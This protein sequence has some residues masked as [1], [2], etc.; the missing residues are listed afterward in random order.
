MGENDFSDIEEQIKNSVQNALNYIDFAGIKNTINTS[1]EKTMNEVKSQ[2]KEK[3]GYF[4]KKMY[5][6]SN[7]I[8]RK[9]EEFTQEKEIEKYINRKP[10]GKYR[11]M[12][13]SIMGGFGSVG[14][15]ITTVILSSIALFGIGG[16]ILESGIMI[17]LSIIGTFFLGS[18]VLAYRGNSI[19]NRLY[20]FRRYSDSLREKKYCSIE[21]LADSINKKKK[22]VIKDLENMM[23]LD[24]FREGH[25]DAEKKYF[26]LSDE[27]Y[28]D[29][30]SS[31][32]S[33]RNRQKAEEMRK[34]DENSEEGNNRSDIETI[35]EAGKEYKSQIRKANEVIMSEK[36][37]EK[38]YKLENIVGEIFKTIEKNPNKMPEVK[39]FIDHYLP[40]TLKLVNSYKELYVQ[41]IESENIKKAK[42]EI[43]KSIDLI[44]TAFENLYDGLYEE[45]AMDIS[46][47]ISVLETLFNQDGLTNSDFKNRK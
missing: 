46:S 8:Q 15:G 33:Y 45:A 30:L 12:I 42:D 31:L 43:E 28:E 27:I 26:M 17:S 34:A 3:S 9:V 1:A 24:M 38:L 32:E 16:N 14:F 11:G 21:E 19:R 18:L 4:D 41:S 23:R 44:N 40:I 13:Y 36:M 39:K 47:D 6:F 25:I 10:H 29:Y 5:D 2:L 22:F 7:N 37:S 20:R 35:I